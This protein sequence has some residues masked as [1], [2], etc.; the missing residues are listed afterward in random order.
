MTLDLCKSGG[1]KISS[2]RHKEKRWTLFYFFSLFRFSLAGGRGTSHKLLLSNLSSLVR[3][4]RNIFKAV[5]IYLSRNIGNHDVCVW[6]CIQLL[7]DYFYPPVFAAIVKLTIGAISNTSRNE[8]IHGRMHWAVSTEEE[9]ECSFSLACILL[10][11]DSLC[12]SNFHTSVAKERC[13]NRSI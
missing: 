10:T 6:S 5:F 11:S 8:Q 2:I 7:S 1:I 12:L 3:L 13:Y 4:R 9:R